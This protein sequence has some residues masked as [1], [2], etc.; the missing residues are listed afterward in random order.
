M[1]QLPSDQHY[2]LPSH[3]RI[4]PTATGAILLDLKR[5][6]YFGLGDKETRAILE[7]AKNGPIAGEKNLGH[8]TV[9]PQTPCIVRELAKAG[10]LIRYPPEGSDIFTVRVEIDCPTTS[11]GHELKHSVPFRFVD[12]SN[13]LRACVWASWAVRMRSLYSVTREIS[14]QKCRFSRDF[15]TQK[16][17][18]LVCIF[19][20]LRPFAFT[21]QDQCL[22]HALALMKFLSLYALFPTWVIGIRARPWAAHSWVQQGSLLL[23]SDPEHVCEFSPIMSV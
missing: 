18:D 13:F 22:F 20:R 12:T 1:S 9:S 23:D 8:K 14:R 2:W 19:R 16:A 3:L 15:D 17:T 4:C 7:V 21:A 11:I 6:R 5:N 10:L